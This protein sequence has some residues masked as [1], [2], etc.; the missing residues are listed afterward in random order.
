M[1]VV[2]LATYVREDR[3]IYICI[4]DMFDANLANVS[5]TRRAHT[6]QEDVFVKFAR[7]KSV[8]S[9]AHGIAC[10]PFIL[11]LGAGLS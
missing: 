2:T 11:A 10:S 4:E 6:F 7:S 1:N 3:N 8:P 5:H 9:V